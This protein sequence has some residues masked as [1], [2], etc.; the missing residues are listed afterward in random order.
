MIR[1]TIS[2]WAGATRYGS[3]SVVTGCGL[4]TR[5]I[6]VGSLVVSEGGS[7]TVAFS[8]LFSISPSRIHGGRFHLVLDKKYPQHQGNDEGVVDVSHQISYPPTCTTNTNFSTLYRREI[9]FCGATFLRKC[10]SITCA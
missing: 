6:T 10:S 3:R 9:C 5:H 7:P 8:C 2:C 1:G 4:K